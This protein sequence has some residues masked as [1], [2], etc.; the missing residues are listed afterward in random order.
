MNSR[1]WVLLLFPFFLFSTVIK[2]Q[3]SPSTSTETLSNKRLNLYLDCR[4]YCDVAYF[5]SQINYINYVRDPELADI[6]L[7]ITRYP[8]ANNGTQY[9][10]N[11]I[12]KG[13]LE[14]VNNVFTKDYPPGIPLDKL[15]KG[16]VQQINLGLVAYLVHTDIDINLSIKEDDVHI[17]SVEDQEDPWNFWVFEVYTSGNLRKESQ[18]R[19][20]Q[21]S[22]GVEMARVTENW[23]I[24]QDV[25]FRG[26]Y[27]KIKKSEEDIIS[28]L[29]RFGIY[30]KAVKSIDDHWSVGVF[31]S[32]YASTFN[33]IQ[34]GMRFGFASEYS[35]FPYPEVANREF[36]I[37]YHFGYNNQNYLEET[38][39][40]KLGETL[41]DQS[42]LLSLRLRQPWG[43]IYSSL[44]GKTFIQDFSKNNLEMKNTV[45]F[46][47][48]KGLSLDL[49]ANFEIINDQLSIPKGEATLEEVLLQQKQ[50]ASDYDLFLSMGFRYNFGS[51][52]NNI[53]NTRL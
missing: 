31:E 18:R 17:E 14:K 20:F 43:S 11:F 19:T 7:L 26:T 42:I 29:R 9:T 36:T 3:I 22:S 2:G 4:T 30:G 1:F 52:Y 50:L 38:I 12:G 15:R 23:R 28:N 24:T 45:S 47:L 46:R 37:A 48:I 21:L 27:R 25:Y 44:R 10:F 33:N 13:A 51:I 35:I 53:V 41:W 40:G 6:H 39:F 49:R 34:A 8:L 16:F 32:I 5:K